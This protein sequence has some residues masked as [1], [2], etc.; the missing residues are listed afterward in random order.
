MHKIYWCGGGMQLE[1]IATN[2]FIENGLNTIM[3]YIMVMIDN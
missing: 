2:N 3:K 1:N